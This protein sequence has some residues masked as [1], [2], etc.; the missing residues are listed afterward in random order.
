MTAGV[1]TS[2]SPQQT[3]LEKVQLLR[4]SGNEAFAAHEY[5]TAVEK[6]K[7]ALL[8]LLQP[9]VAC[10]QEA[11]TVAVALRTNLAAC[12][13][14]LAQF[15]AAA[16]ECSAAL[17]IKP[18]HAKAL[19]R[20]AEARLGLGQ[21][22]EALLDAEAARVGAPND[23]AVADLV[24]DIEDA[25][26]LAPSK[27]QHAPAASRAMPPSALQPQ[28]RQFADECMAEVHTEFLTTGGAVETEL[29]LLHLTPDGAKYGRITLKGAFASAASLQSATAYVRGMHTTV[30]AEAA[31]LIVKRSDVA[32][33]CVWFAG[34]WPEAL[35]FEAA[36][37]FVQL[38][39]PHGSCT[40]FMQQRGGSPMLEPAV[41]LPDDCSL[42]DPSSIFSV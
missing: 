41:E 24:Y 34:T 18:R 38:V 42:L 23:T 9:Q 11:N 6:Y 14:K 2:P 22:R 20:R 4:A 37:V 5:T 3:V 36:G 8:L 39:S 10:S 7:Q 32:F 29:R 40:W 30:D 12:H 31:V 27:E 26:A 21:L 13:L 17:A 33:P 15:A 1:V 35:S 28:L 25:I 19:F 16:E